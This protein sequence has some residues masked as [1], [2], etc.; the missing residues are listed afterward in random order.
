MYLFFVRM[1][2]YIPEKKIIGAHARVRSEIS[3]YKGLT[4]R[5]YIPRGSGGER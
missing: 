5:A 3:T 1:S 2:M 4:F